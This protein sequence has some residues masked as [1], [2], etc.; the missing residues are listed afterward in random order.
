MQLLLFR[1]AILQISSFLYAAGCFFDSS[2]SLR[3][4]EL[5]HTTSQKSLSTTFSA[6]TN[7]DAITIIYSPEVLHSP[8][9]RLENVQSPSKVINLQDNL[10]AITCGI[11]TDCCHLNNWL[12][13]Q[14]ILQNQIFGSELLITRLATLLGEYMHHKSLWPLRPFG[15]TIILLGYDPNNGPK[16][17]EIDPIGNCYDCRYTSIGAG[18]KDI[19]KNW[20]RSKDPT[21]MELKHLISES[22]QLFLK[23]NEDSESD[24]RCQEDEK[25]CIELYIVGQSVPKLCK[26]NL[27]E[28]FTSMKS[29]SSDESWLMTKLE[30]I[31]LQTTQ[32]HLPPTFGNLG[33]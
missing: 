29:H 20:D 24:F 5:A 22:L 14:V 7:G 21:K 19:A 33:V 15:A 31:I 26:I 16:I 3:Q 18:S 6:R 30:E 12:F 11:F 23:A 2:G 32:I 27:T 28:L 10:A 17:I 13:D 8:D 1:V 4:V 25:F 9:C